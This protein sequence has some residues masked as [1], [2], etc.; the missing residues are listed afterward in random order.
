VA[1]PLASFFGG[2][3]AAIE[4][5]KEVYLKYH[6][7]WL[8]KRGAFVGQDRTMFNSLSLLFPGRI[9]TVWPRDPY[10][11]AALENEVHPLGACGNLCVLFLTPIVTTSRS[12]LCELPIDSDVDTRLAGGTSATSFPHDR[13]G[14]R[15]AHSSSRASGACLGNSSLLLRS[16]D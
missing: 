3:P 14:R 16:A 2:T 7:Y 15:L 12:R 6:D 10:A 8:F 5:W 9:I 4:W 13:N 1:P 11:P